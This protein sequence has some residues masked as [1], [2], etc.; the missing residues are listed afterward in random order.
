MCITVGTGRTC[1]GIVILVV[2]D[3]YGFARGCAKP[4]DRV[5]PLQVRS[6]APDPD[7]NQKDQHSSDNHL[8]CGLEKRRIHIALSDPADDQEFDSHDHNGNGRS[9]S[10]FWNQIWQ[11]VTD[12]SEEHTSEL[13]SPDHLVCRLLLE[14]KK[15][16]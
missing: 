9:S 8:K 16:R 13:Q 2:A 4:L 5:L 6:R 11:G 7:P 10:K 3:D 1:G 15:T 12:R 14:K